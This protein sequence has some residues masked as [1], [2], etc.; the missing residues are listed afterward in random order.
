MTISECV[1][2]SPGWGVVKSLEL[3]GS[4]PEGLIHMYKVGIKYKNAPRLKVTSSRP[5]SSARRCGARVHSCRL[6][7]SPH[8]GR[9]SSEKQLLFFLESQPAK[10]GRGEK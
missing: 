7:T 2:S 10:T 3:I 5:S 4:G 1:R 8:T 6:R 9:C